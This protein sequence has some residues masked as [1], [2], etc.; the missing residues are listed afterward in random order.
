VKGARGS[1]LPAHQVQEAAVL[2][3][4]HVR[5]KSA[6]DQKRMYMFERLARF[7]RCQAC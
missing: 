5:H 1:L 3:Q 2:Q 6:L 7:I 4:V